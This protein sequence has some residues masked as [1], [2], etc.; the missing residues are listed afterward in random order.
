MSQNNTQFDV[1][2]KSGIYLITCIPLNKHYVGTSNHVVRRLNAHKSFLKN[3]CH[4][5]KILQED[6]DKYGLSYFLF[7]KLQ[8]GAGLE[9]KELENLETTILLTLSSEQRY[10]V[11]TNW[12]KRGSQTNPFYNKTHTMEARQI[13]SL[14]NIGKK[15]PFKG[16]T[17][18]NKLKKDIS[19][20]NSGTSSAER[21][22]PLY[23]DDV[24]YESVSEA[25][26]KTG[27]QR[28]FIRN[29][30]HST[31][32]RFQHYQWADKKIN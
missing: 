21:R 9:Q 15:S 10:N 7:Q 16:L 6:Y 28:R 17:H 11:Y 1:S 4:D 26:E 12:R 18:T 22:K 29:R 23:I 2:M 19:K 3:G 32:E 5:N 24:Y 30:C 31:E 25:S 8:L 14:A 27:I 13:Q 20:Q